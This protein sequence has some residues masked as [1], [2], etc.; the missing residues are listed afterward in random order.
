M[1]KNDSGVDYVDILFFVGACL[2]VAGVYGM[3]GTYP[4][5]TAA[6]ALLYIPAM[7]NI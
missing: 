7:R 1:K 5:M 6:G 2:I 3:L 4:A